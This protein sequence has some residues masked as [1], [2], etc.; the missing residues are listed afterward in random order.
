VEGEDSCGQKTGTL[1]T[2]YCGVTRGEGT[3]VKIGATRLEVGVVVPPRVEDRLPYVGMSA[4]QTQWAGQ[5]GKPR[6]ST[7]LAHQL[8]VT[9]FINAITDLPSGSESYSIP[10]WTVP[11]V[12]APVVVPEP[13]SALAALYQRIKN[14]NEEV[15]RHRMRYNVRTFTE[16]KTYRKKTAVNVEKVHQISASQMT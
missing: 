15:P 9:T 6:S 4:W 1:S 12:A 14:K 2:H 5:Q 11:G 13:G 7:V 16:V 8:S 3:Y 10:I